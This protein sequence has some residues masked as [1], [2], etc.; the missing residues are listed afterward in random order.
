MEMNRKKFAEPF[1]QSRNS[2]TGKRAKIKT[3][4]PEMVERRDLHGH[5]KGLR[6]K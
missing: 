2:E 5:V 6:D 1:Q 4:I 3:N